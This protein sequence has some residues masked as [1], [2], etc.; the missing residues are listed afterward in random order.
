MSVPKRRPP[1]PHSCSWSRSPLRQRA[2]AN[3]S[4]VMKTKRTTKTISA[5]Q[6]TS[7][8]T[9]LPR[10]SLCFWLASRSAA[11]RYMRDGEIDNG[12]QDCSE[13]HAEKLI[14]IEERNADEGGF[15]FI[16]ESRPDDHGKL[17]QKQQIPPAPAGVWIAALAHVSPSRPCISRPRR[18]FWSGRRESNPRNQLGKLMFYHLTTPALFCRITA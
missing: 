16:V 1:R 11:P 4:Q 10:F 12:R 6:L 15:D 17:N 3:P 9:S 14:P 8:T 18:F 5:V 2:A 7:C 13:D